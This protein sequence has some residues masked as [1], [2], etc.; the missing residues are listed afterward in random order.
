M[1]LGCHIAVFTLTGIYILS[2]CALQG[3]PTPC[4]IGLSA[5]TFLA[6][7]HAVDEVIGCIV[8]SAPCESQLPLIK[9][10]SPPSFNM[11]H[12]SV[13]CFTAHTWHPFLQF[14]ICYPAALQ[15]NSTHVDWVALFCHHD[16]FGFILPHCRC[17]MYIIVQMDFPILVW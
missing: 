12:C 9:K 8:R 7:R 16:W 2:W 10:W 5:G 6:L 13:V 14:A 15:L 4:S 3:S 1:W 11:V 17:S